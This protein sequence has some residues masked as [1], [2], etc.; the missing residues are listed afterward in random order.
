LRTPVKDAVRHND[1]S[2]HWRRRVWCSWCSTQLHIN[3]IMS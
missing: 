2:C 3:W 1:L